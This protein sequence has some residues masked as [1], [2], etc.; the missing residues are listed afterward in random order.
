MKIGAFKTEPL[1]DSKLD[2]PLPIPVS[3]VRR[4]GSSLLDPVWMV[5]C[6]IRSEPFSS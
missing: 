5:V 2:I 4:K 6:I 3:H 1:L